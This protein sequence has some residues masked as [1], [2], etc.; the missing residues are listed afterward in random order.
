VRWVRW[1]FNQPPGPF[2][3]A[4]DPSDGHGLSQIQHVR[5]LYAALDEILA[6]CPE[7]VIE[8]C[9]GGGTRIEPGILRRGHTYWINDQSSSPH[10]VR[11][12]Q[13]GMNTFWPAH[14]ANMNVVAHDGLLSESEW[15]SHQA[16]SFGVSAPLVDW[17]ADTLAAL[18][19]Q[20]ARYKRFRGTLEEDFASETGQ[21]ARLTGKH[22]LAFGTGA[23][24]LVM[25]HDLDSGGVSLQLPRD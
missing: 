6:A 2:W 24:Q 22:H 8:Q 19:S 17:S 9:A 4:N 10:L 12:F 11:F 25:E 7:L 16:G 18:A 5:G 23:R 3:L 20:V 13:H 14:Y 1:D 21:P 15:L